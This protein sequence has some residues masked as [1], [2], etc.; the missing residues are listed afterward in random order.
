[1]SIL[2]SIKSLLSPKPVQVEPVTE[3]ITIAPP[4]RGWREGMWVMD[5]EQVGI[6]FK[7]DNVSEIH[8]VN[9][10][11]GETSGIVR[12]SLTAL[13]QCKYLE[14]PE[15]RRG[16]SQEKAEELGYGS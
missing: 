3:I 5:G 4:I 11:T 12:R 10:D 16:V 1:M 2:S 6:L 7:L 14:I 13:R 15:C 8:Y 9:K